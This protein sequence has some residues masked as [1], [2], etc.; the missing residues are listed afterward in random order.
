MEKIK[1]I[2]SGIYNPFIVPVLV[3]LIFLNTCNSST[4]V[5]SKKIDRLE[6]KL[7]S[8]EKKVGMLPNKS[9][10][11]IEGLKAEKRMIQATDRK[12]LDV[13]RQNEID[14][15]IAEIEKFSK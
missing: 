14:K 4:K 11:K 3:T 2:F 15:E 9:D 7:D 6:N 1:K 10:M 8:L 13:N 5:V 12:I